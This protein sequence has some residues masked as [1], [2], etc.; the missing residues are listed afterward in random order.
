MID[1]KWN[2]NIHDIKKSISFF[3]KHVTF[4]RTTFPKH[5]RF[6]IPVNNS[7]M[8]VAMIPIIYLNR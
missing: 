4:A 1:G 2:G 7:L 6:I 3:I 8:H 5:I